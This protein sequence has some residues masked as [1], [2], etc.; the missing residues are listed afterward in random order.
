ML[1]RDARYLSSFDIA[2]EVLTKALRDNQNIQGVKYACYETKLALYADDLVL[3]VQSPLDSMIGLTKI[4]GK[5]EI[6]GYKVNEKTSRIMGLN[7]KEGLRTKL[8]A[9]YKMPWVQKG[10]RYLGIKNL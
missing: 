3:F 6:S 10:I 7:I 9:L 2:I 8:Q 1:G 5:S 4:L